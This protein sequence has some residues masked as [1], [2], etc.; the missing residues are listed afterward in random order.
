MILAAVNDPFLLYSVRRAAQP[1][2]DVFDSEYDVAKALDLG[3]P[4]V[5]VLCQNSLTQTQVP[6]MTKNADPLGVAVFFGLCKNRLRGLGRGAYGR[7][8]RRWR[9]RSRRTAASRLRLRCAEG[10]S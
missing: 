2:E 1:A 7:L 3:F 6:R 9:R 4:R 10:F 5:A 8:P